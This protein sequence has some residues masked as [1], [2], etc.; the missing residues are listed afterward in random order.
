M[1][2]ALR[3]RVAAYLAKHTTLTLATVGPDGAPHSAPLFYASDET[4]NLYFLSSPDSRH[5]QNVALNARVAAAIY[6]EVW[7]WQAIRGLQLD[8]EVEPLAGAE[9]V[10]AEVLYQAK[11]P[12]VADLSRQV[13]ASTFYRLHPRWLRYLDNSV[14]FGWR[15]E[16][17]L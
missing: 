4:L 9:R 17:E 3:R 8:G 5:S 11:Y 13:E 6:D 16:M 15:E 10:Q 1:S 14:A 2:E 7:Q 12:F